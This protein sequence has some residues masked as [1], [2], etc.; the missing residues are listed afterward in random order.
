M[1]ISLKGNNIDLKRIDFDDFWEDYLDYSAVVDY[2]LD[3]YDNTYRKV[4]LPIGEFRVSDLLLQLYD[5]DK[6]KLYDELE[7][8]IDNLYCDVRYDVEHW[9]EGDE[10]INFL[11]WEIT[12][13]KAGKTQLI[14]LIDEE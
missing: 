9:T 14:D 13:V 4:D 11:G 10:P 5:Y 6:F 12:L 8:D 1:V 3:I 7:W 2:L